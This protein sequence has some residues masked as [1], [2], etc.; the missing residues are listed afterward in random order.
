MKLGLNTII[1]GPP[2]T[3]KTHL[4]T[5]EIVPQLIE[6]QVNTDEHI[7]II[8]SFELW[9][10]MAIELYLSSNTAV[11]P[12]KLAASY[13][14]QNWGRSH[15]I[16]PGM[17][18]GDVWRT[19]Q[20]HSHSDLSRKKE[21]YI[22]KKIDGNK[23]LLNDEGIKHVEEEYDHEVDKLQLSLEV[24]DSHSFVEFIT[25]HQSYSYEEF[26]EGIRPVLMTSG[27][28]SSDV[29][30]RLEDGILKRMCVRA[31][32][33]PR[34]NYVLAIDEINRGNVSKIFGELITLIE[35][36]KRG[37]SDHELTVTLPYSKTSFSVPKNLYI[38]GTMNTADRSIALL[39]VALRRR[40][41]FMELMPDYTLLEDINIAGL[42]VS[43]LLE[44]LNT[45]L[46][47]MIDR[48]HQ[49]GHSYF[50][51]LLRSENPDKDLHEIWYKRIIPLV[52]EYFYNDWSRLSQILGEYDAKSKKGFV[53]MLSAEE[54][55]DL[56]G[57]DSEFTEASIGSIRQF[58]S[59]GLIEALKL[60]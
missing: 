27:G 37:G 1:Y 24:K 55:S 56:L 6:G 48:D 26:I 51:K 12:G 9:E 36:D 33:D 17:L 18:T 44:K 57:S 25:F 53:E 39:D 8:D 15:S 13:L 3:G 60:F 59:K 58:S 16:Q 23:W 45:K 41:N 19:L 46:C 54:I 7:R 31:K 28:T 49:I 50:M 35:E 29:Q 4:V 43:S 38:I 47:V 22:F 2:G 30:Y 34:N 20:Q 52:Q 14:L 21:P 5:Q 42:S 10:T 32:R 40:F 11:E